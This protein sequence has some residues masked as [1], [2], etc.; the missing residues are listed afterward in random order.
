VKRKTTVNIYDMEF[1][2]IGEESEEYMLKVA[3]LVDSR[4]RQVAVGGRST[5]DAAIL[6]AA[7]IADD[8]FKA[9]DTAD[10][11]KRQLRDYFEEISRLKDEM[12]E[13]KRASRAPR[14]RGRRAA[15]EAEE[16]AETAAEEPAEKDPD[17]PE[18]L[19]F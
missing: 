8:Y 3:E 11:M 5:V 2:L 16:T 9:L 6:T 4:M 10:A 18:Q 12:D 13:L 15:A 17:E 19:E 14:G 1:T 7:N